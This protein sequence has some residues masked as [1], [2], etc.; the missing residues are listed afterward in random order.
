MPM[1]KKSRSSAAKRVTGGAGRSTKTARKSTTK[2]AARAM[3]KRTTK[4]TKRAAPKRKRSLIGRLMHPF[5]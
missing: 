2:S 5:G 1:K 3:P 4:A